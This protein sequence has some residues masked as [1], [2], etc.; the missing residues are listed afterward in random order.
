MTSGVIQARA[1]REERAQRRVERFVARFEPG[2]YELVCHA[3]LPLVLTPEL[4]SYLRNEFLPGLPWMAEVDLLLSGLCSQVGYELYVMDTDVRA[5]VLKMRSETFDAARMGEVAN[6]LISY[7]RYLANNRSQ[8]SD[9]ELTSQQW[10]AMVYLGAAERQQV[11][12]EI[13]ERFQA[14]SVGGA[15]VGAGLLGA[16]EMAQL[17]EITQSFGEKLAEYPELIEYAELVS[18]VQLR[19]IALAAE[20]VERVYEVGGQRLQ[21]PN[22][23]KQTLS[24]KG[25]IRRLRVDEA[26]SALLNELGLEIA[27]KE[28]AGP[29]PIQGREISDIE[30]PPL[31]V[32][33]FD[34]GELIEND[35]ELI[36][37]TSNT[38][39]T[40]PP[41]EPVNFQV[42]TISL[43]QQALE[44]FE[45]DTAKIEF[46]RATQQEPL[47]RWVVV[48]N[49]SQARRFVEQ[50]ADDLDLEM[51]AIPGGTFVMGSPVSE[52][53]RYADEAQHEVTVPDCFMGRYPVTQLQ[54]QFIA[55]LPVVNR[56]LL[57]NPSRFQDGNY[58]VHEVSWYDATEFCNRLSAY[59]RCDYRL[60]TEAEWEHACRA[61]TTTP[62]CFGNTIV[63]EVANYNNKN[64]ANAYTP[65]GLYRD[66]PTPVDGFEVA[67]AFGLCDVHGNVWEW[68][69][70]HYG[71]YEQTPIDGSAYLTNDDGATRVFRSGFWSSNP[72]DCRSAF[73]YSSK[74]SNRHNYFGFRVCC[75]MISR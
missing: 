8:M 26:D 61:G 50:L 31:Q 35:V 13:V 63:P 65:R 57:S 12:D 28:E 67:N 46:R 73:R 38:F 36:N 5:Y 18:D 10:A 53:G 25:R 44:V 51:V 72:S 19:N 62:F 74:P 48:K 75:S 4:V 11:V 66:R 41:L 37:D 39:D 14:C 55:S 16:A 2:Y 22:E 64:Y 45:F 56:G 68:C 43:P 49:R 29:S 60:P 24:T 20:R 70:D 17:A 3:A 52:S 23:M 34:Y 54:W 47:D 58:P 30:F 42:A 15:Q 59:T 6:L 33:E 32:L 69:Q 71:K 27:R 21:L 7:V 1:Q 40:F 9:R